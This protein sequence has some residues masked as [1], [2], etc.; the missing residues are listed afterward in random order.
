MIEATIERRPPE[1]ATGRSASVVERA[2]ITEII[3]FR[4]VP[5]AHS[6]GVLTVGAVRGRAAVDDRAIKGR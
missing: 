6:T 3:V 1:P 4:P 5:E 2:R